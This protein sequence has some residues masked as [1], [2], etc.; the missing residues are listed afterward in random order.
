MYSRLFSIKGKKSCILLSSV[1]LG[2]ADFSDLAES[3]LRQNYKELLGSEA[4]GN[5]SEK[6]FA[7]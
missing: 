7:P 2:V 4:S 1:I 5:V 6:H 3:V